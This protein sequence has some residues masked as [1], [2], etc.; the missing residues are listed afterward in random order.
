MKIAF[1]GS[2]PSSLYAAFLLSAKYRDAQISIYEKEAKL[3][4][5]LRSTGNG[6]ANL[7]PDYKTKGDIASAY[8]CP[9]FVEPLLI[10]YPVERRLGFFD[11]IGTPLIYED[12]AGYYPY[13]RNAS[14]FA[15]YLIEALKDRGVI[16][17]PSIK[18][19][20]YAVDNHRIDL[21][22]ENGSK[23]ATDIFI[24]APGALSG[25]NLGSDGNFVRV[26]KRHGYSLSPYRPGLCPVKVAETDLASLTGLRF[27]VVLSVYRDGE[28]IFSEPGEVLYK[29]DGLSGIVAMNASSILAREGPSDASYSLSLDFFPDKTSGELRVFLEK[30]RRINPRF[31]LDGIFPRAF[32]SHLFNRVKRF[33]DV[34]TLSALA[35]VLK[36]LR[37]SYAGNYGFPDSQASVGGLSLDELAFGFSSKK[38]HGVYFAGEVLDVD[39]L[40]G[41]Y[42]L[43]FDLLNA[44]SVAEFL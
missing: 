3:A 44:L 40:C 24:V 6:K 21:V 25:R 31:Y 17:H 15:D 9:R 29:K 14:L 32:S 19:M 34:D 13:L 5:K 27:K 41:G 2:G 30:L 4:K 11:E 7:L 39:G 18:I 16:F 28:I 26:L 33:Q 1:L 22:L 8:N 35:N 12:G 20:D 38:E 10:K 37:Y 42:N 23:A 43:Q 36:G